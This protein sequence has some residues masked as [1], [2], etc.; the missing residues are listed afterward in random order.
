[1]K[2]SAVT[3]AVSYSTTVPYTSKYYF[4]VLGRKLWIR[5]YGGQTVAVAEDCYYLT[6]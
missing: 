4:E 6:N 1:M 3:E 5:D 2:K